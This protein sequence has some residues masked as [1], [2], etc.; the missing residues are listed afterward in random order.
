MNPF[1]F[2]HWDVF[3]IPQSNVMQTGIS[4]TKNNKTK[5]N[6]NT[7]KLLLTACLQ[8]R[9]LHCRF[10]FS[11]KPI[12]IIRTPSSS[13]N[14]L[15][16]AAPFLRSLTFSNTLKLGCLTLLI[17]TNPMYFWRYYEGF[18]MNKYGCSSHFSVQIGLHY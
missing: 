17:A 14:L 12:N 1:M 3:S 2:Y 10:C 6:V 15:S 4:F 16:S 5:H 13:N 7:W 18:S 11:T 8:N 9:G